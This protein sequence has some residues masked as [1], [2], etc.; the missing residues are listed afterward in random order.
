MD[1]WPG[2][3]VRRMPERG[4]GQ[5]CIVSNR[6]GDSTT[7]GGAI[8]SAI[9]D[10]PTIGVPVTGT[11][12]YDRPVLMHSTLEAS[13]SSPLP[14]LCRQA[15]MLIE[16]APTMIDVGRF[17]SRTC[18]G[19]S[20][21][22]VSATGD[23]AAVSA[24]GPSPPRRIPS[25]RVKSVLFVFLWGAPSHLDTC[26][27]KPDAPVGISR[28][29]R[30]HQDADRGS[31]FSRSSPAAH[32]PA[33]SAHRFALVRSHVT[34]APGHPDAGTVALTGFEEAP[35][36]VQPNFRVDHR[37]TPCASACGAA[38]VLFDR[39]RLRWRIPRAELKA[40]AAGRSAGRYD[41]FMVGAS[42]AGE[43]SIPALNLL[44]DL[45]PARIGDRPVAAHATGPC[46]AA[47]GRATGSAGW[48]RT[49]QNAYALL[50]EPTARKA[51]DLTLESPRDRGAL[52]AARF[53]ARGALLARRLVEAGVPYVQLNYSRHPEAINPGFEFGWDTHI[54]NFELLQDQHCPVFDRGVL[55]AAG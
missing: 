31:Q 37:Q 27:P 32:R 1:L 51:F 13:G 29:I 36:P 7:H 4:R 28:A 20:R 21:P 3:A 24:G 19:V 26:D 23:R 46:S 50:S 38:A 35:D 8:S 18:S 30:R 48:Q 34:S 22:V 41:P 16:G 45:N 54:Y 55:R 6:N 49:Y 42:E 12:G 5:A 43:V 9:G 52:T 39:E 15:R 17:L 33:A 10:C 25:P 40:T 47:A 11:V 2:P 53:L 14:L 44:D